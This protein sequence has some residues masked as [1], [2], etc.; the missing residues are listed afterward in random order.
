MNQKPSLPDSLRIQ[1]GTGKHERPI[2]RRATFKNQP[3]TSAQERELIR[4]SGLKERGEREDGGVMNDKSNPSEGK[5]R[6]AHTQW[7]CTR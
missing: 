6:Q 1:S 3:R 4:L 2:D 7:G 5:T